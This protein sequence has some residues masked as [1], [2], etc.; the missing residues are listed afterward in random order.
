M[1]AEYLVQ[2]A[3]I[4]DGK[5]V[6]TAYEAYS[7]IIRIL[8]R[9]NSERQKQ[10]K[11][12]AA[13]EFRIVTTQDISVVCKAVSQRAALHI[14]YCM[15]QHVVRDV[16]YDAVYDAAAVRRQEF[17]KQQECLKEALPD[18]RNK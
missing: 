18:P 11:D 8:G 14:A 12:P 2:Y 6:S 3:I 10:G 7:E 9:R 4:A 17:E 13:L 5:V 16:H 1:T 15:N